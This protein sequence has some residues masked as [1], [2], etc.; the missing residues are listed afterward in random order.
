MVL[1][2]S[3]PHPLT[4]LVCAVAEHEELGWRLCHIRNQARRSLAGVAEP[5]R[6]VW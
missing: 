6:G 4:L 5:L 1:P 2:V 3:Q